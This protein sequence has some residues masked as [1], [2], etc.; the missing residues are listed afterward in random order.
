MKDIIAALKA[1][2]R[3]RCEVLEA[4]EAIANA[5]G[6]LP[7]EPFFEPVSAVSIE[8]SKRKMITIG[9]EAVAAWAAHVAYASRA[10]MRALE[11]PILRDIHDGNLTASAAL[12]R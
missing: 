2:Y 10:R 11:T 8:N 4:I 1:Q 5:V 12:L 9:A 7:F 3:E 6:A